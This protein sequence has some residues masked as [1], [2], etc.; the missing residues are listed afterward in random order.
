MAGTLIMQFDICRS[1]ISLTSPNALNHWDQMV[2]AFLAHG[3]QAP[4]HLK[5]LLDAAPDFAMAH[6]AKSLFSMMMGRRE[7]VEVAAAASADAQRYLLAGGATRREHL[8][9]EAAAAWING[10]P[11]VAIN[12]LEEAMQRNPADTLTLKVVHAIRFILGDNFGMRHSVEAV[13]DAHGMDHPLRGYALGCHAFALEETGCYDEAERV[14]L[15]ALHFAT[16]DAWGL[17]AV[18][19]VYDM[20]HR[21]RA[22][23]AVIESNG[24]AWAHCNNFR[25]HVWW[26]KALLHLDEGE[27]DVVLNLYDEKIRAEKTDDYRDF[28]NASSLLMRLEL[29]GVDVGDRWTELADLAETRS[30]D[31][32]LVFADLHYML[33]LI[34][35]D[36]D[37]AAARMTSRIARDAGGLGEMAAVTRD[38]GQAAAQGLTAFG[39]ARFGDAFQMLNAARPRFQVMG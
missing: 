2:L 9:C 4:V 38:P 18:A 13:I 5:N 1:P 14:G 8:W 11:T 28:S 12:R 6:A 16:D 19:H 37:D 3:S 36:R 20:T 30:D 29:E 23:I 34:G 32:C 24:C 25:F 10:R 33:A 21:P 27:Y 31:G 35:D 17:H 22:G 39:E 26:H 7:L 15:D